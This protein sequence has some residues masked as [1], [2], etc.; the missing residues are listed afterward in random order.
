MTKVYVNEQGD[1]YIISN[2]NEELIFWLEENT[3]SYHI[4]PLESSLKNINVWIFFDD[5]A[6][7]IA[8]KLRWI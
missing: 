6:D 4:L 2:W 7:D 3:P 5:P 8:F 1:K